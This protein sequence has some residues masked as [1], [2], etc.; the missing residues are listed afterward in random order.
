MA[1]RDVTLC[2]GEDVSGPVSRVVRVSEPDHGMRL[3]LRA[4]DRAKILDEQG[5]R[6]LYCQR[7]FGSVV[8]QRGRE[9]VLRCE[10]DHMIPYCYSYDGRASNIAAACQLCNRGKGSKVFSTLDQARVWLMQFHANRGVCEE[11]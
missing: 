10:W 7:R 2:C 6:C 9:T 4:G 8:Y 1:P 5:Y 3:G 11:P